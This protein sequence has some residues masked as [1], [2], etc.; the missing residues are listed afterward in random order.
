MSFVPLRRPRL[1]QS[2]GDRIDWMNA[3]GLTL[4][5]SP[6]TLE[7]G[8]GHRP[9]TVTGTKKVIGSPG[10]GIGFGATDGIGTTDKISISQF[11][12]AVQR[13]YFVLAKLN[14]F[15]G[16]GF[17]RFIEDLTPGN[18]LFYVNNT[19][20]LVYWR[21]FDTGNRT[22]NT[23]TATSV[24]DKFGKVTAFSV[25]FDSSS[26]SNQAELYIDGVRYPFSTGDGVPT[27]NAIAY[28]G[29]AVGNR[30]SDNARSCDG[31]IYVVRSFDRMLSAKEHAELAA[32][33]NRVFL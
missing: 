20:G 27:G 29:I 30:V 16:G 11:L 23:G 26:P 22:A 24:S 1:S 18:D 3:Q 19:Y 2:R 10:T 7:D 17:G 21:Q 13:S 25:S 6:N 14:G 5:L 12:P 31:T 9:I 4:D 8:V 32:N 15:G 33:P 28:N